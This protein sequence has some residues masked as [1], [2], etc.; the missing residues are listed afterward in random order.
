MNLKA[1]TKPGT[2]AIYRNCRISLDSYDIF[3]DKKQP[4]DKSGCSYCPC[5]LANFFY[6]PTAI[7]REL[8][9]IPAAPEPP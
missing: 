4:D 9:F 1:K 3:Q 5:V 2:I 6:S 7:Q 8:A